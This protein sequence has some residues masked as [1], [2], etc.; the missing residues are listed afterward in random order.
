MA[1]WAL[2]SNVAPSIILCFCGV[3][4]PSR[5]K[6]CIISSWRCNLKNSSLNN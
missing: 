6:A 3:T 2:S 1:F 4:M 5:K